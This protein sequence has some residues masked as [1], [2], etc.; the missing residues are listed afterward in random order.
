MSIISLTEALDFLDIMEPEEGPGS[1]SVTDGDYTEAEA[2][3][4]LNAAINQFDTATSTGT[5]YIAGSYD[6][7]TTTYTF[8]SSASTTLIWTYVNDDG[9]LTFT[10]DHEAGEQ[11]ATT[12]DL[13]P[14]DVVQ[15][16]LDAADKFVKIYCRRDIESTSFVERHDGN[17]KSY[18]YLENYPVTA[19]SRLAI[20]TLDAIKAR[21]TNTTGTASVSVSSTSVT[22]TRNGTDTT[23][24]LATYTTMTTLVAAI[25]AT[26]GWESSLVNSTYGDY[27]STDL[28]P[29]MGL[30]AVNNNWVYLPMPYDAEDDFD[31]DEETGLIELPGGTFSKGRKNILIGYTAGYSSATMPED[32]KTAVK[33]IVKDWY[34]KRDESSFGL[35]GYGIAGMSKQIADTIPREAREILD[36]YVRRMV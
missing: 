26:S 17:G 15:D 18:L 8:D 34:E 2:L 5:L 30:S 23:L 10:F 35:S 25:A 24:A 12:A 31:V 6:E 7:Q 19:V 3:V 9:N 33:I 13:D 27:L 20:G 16:L 22:L 4:E 11:E 21:N 1:I 36:H 29:R 32:L 28:I 14:D